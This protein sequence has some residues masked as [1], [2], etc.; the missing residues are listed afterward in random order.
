MA[1]EEVKFLQKQRERKLGIPAVSSG[2]AQSAG[3]N[4]AA[5]AAASTAINNKNK[6][7]KVNDGVLQHNS[8]AGEAAA[9]ADKDD[10][11]LQD[12]FAQETAVMVEDPNMY[13][14]PLLL[15]RSLKF[16]CKLTYLIL[17]IIP[18]TTAMQFGRLSSP[19]GTSSSRFA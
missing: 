17:L 7:K 5:A 9:D 16:T 12:T 11:V 14:S 4:S 18:I 6:N 1:L 15:L 19:V 3:G 2:S 10:L 8:K 13:D